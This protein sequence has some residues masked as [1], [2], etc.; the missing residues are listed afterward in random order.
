M[1]QLAVRDVVV[2]TNARGP[3]REKYNPANETV[4]VHDRTRRRIQCNNN[5][6]F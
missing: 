2:R 5:I 6:S 4:R 1:L 3:K